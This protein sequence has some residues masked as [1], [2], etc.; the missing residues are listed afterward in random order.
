MKFV[1][2]GF[3]SP[4]FQ[5]TITEKDGKTIEK[6]MIA[7]VGNFHYAKREGES[8]EYE[9]DPKTIAD[10]EA[11]LKA[12]KEAVEKK[13]RF[14]HDMIFRGIVLAGGVPDWVYAVA[15]SKDGQLVAG[16]AANGE[17]RVWKTSDGSQVSSFN[18]T[19]GYS[20]PKAT[21]VAPKK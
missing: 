12:V 1:P 2:G 19:P 10:L 6:L 13:N 11:A 5:V 20:A 15:I 14:H 18:A 16:G 4:A 3:T 21:A 7:K 8:G 17:V 9:V